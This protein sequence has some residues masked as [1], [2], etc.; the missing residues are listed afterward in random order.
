MSFQ[1]PGENLV[2]IQNV[3]RQWI[4]VC[5]VSTQLNIMQHVQAYIHTISNTKIL[6]LKLWL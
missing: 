3:H 5:V 4:H 6:F 1:V 2:D